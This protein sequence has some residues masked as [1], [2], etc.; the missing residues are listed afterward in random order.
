M[1]KPRRRGVHTG[2]LRFLM[3]LASFPSLDGGG[4]VYSGMI[5]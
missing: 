1:K 5:A 4:L 3:A 2:P